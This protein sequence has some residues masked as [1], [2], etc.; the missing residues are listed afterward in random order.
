VLSDAATIREAFKDERFAGRP[1]LR[2]L[3]ERS[4]G[5]PRGNL[6]LNLAIV[7]NA[8]FGNNLMMITYPHIIKRPPINIFIGTRINDTSLE[9]FESS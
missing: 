4:W 1:P 6:N 9:Y 7:T 3:L 2:L 8:L 5:A